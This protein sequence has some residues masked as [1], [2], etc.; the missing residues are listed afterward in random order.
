MALYSRFVLRV[1]YG[2]GALHSLDVHVGLVDDSLDILRHS[3][4]YSA[5]KWI[6]VTHCYSGMKIKHTVHL[7]KLLLRIQYIY[8]ERS[9]V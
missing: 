2:H 9:V 5:V 1:H 3:D 4:V 8:L 7:R 6:C